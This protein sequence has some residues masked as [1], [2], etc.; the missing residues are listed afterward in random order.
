MK[1][2]MQMAVVCLLAISTAAYAGDSRKGTKGAADKAS[3]TSCSP[4]C[5]KTS[6]D[7]TSCSTPCTKEKCGMKKS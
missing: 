3:V 2:I 5:K 4:A 6:C 1:K 7:K